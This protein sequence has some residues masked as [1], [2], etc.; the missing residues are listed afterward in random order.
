METFAEAIKVL[1][2]KRLVPTIIG[3]VTGVLIYAFTPERNGLLVKLGKEWYILLFSGIMFL[4]CTLIQF[5]ITN[6][7]K[8]LLKKDNKIENARFE[9]QQ[10]DK[11]AYDTWDYMDNLRERDRKIILDLLENGNKPIKREVNYRLL[12][13]FEGSYADDRVLSCRKVENND[14]LEDEFVLEIEF[15]KR[16]LFVK[17]KYKRLSRFE[18]V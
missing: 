13:G 16:L 4:I 6:I 7:P 14:K 2:E 3:L 5:I 12:G 15:Y 9:R 17:S 18:E 10:E 1:F 8:W 11:I